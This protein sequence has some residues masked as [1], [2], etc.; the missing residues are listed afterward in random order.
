MASVC[1]FIITVIL[2]EHC[3]CRCSHLALLQRWKS[4]VLMFVFVTHTTTTNTRIHFQYK[5]PTLFQQLTKYHILIIK[6][7]E[8]HYFSNLFW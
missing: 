4:E 1:N 8:M 5:M 7:N 2:H 3:Q 6:A